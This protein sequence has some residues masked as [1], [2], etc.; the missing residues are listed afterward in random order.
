[1]P[2][3]SKPERELIILSV[4]ILTN[5][6][7][8][9]HSSF[10]CC[11]PELFGSFMI[12]T[13]SVFID[14]RRYNCTYQE[15][16]DMS[17]QRDGT[18]LHGLGNLRNVVQLL[19]PCY[20]HD[21]VEQAALIWLDAM[22]NTQ[23]RQKTLVETF[24]LRAREW[25]KVRHVLA[26]PFSKSSITVIVLLCQVF[27]A[28]G[29]AIYEQ[30]TIP[31]H[32]VEQLLL[33]TRCLESTC[34][35]IVRWSSQH[36]EESSLE[37]YILEM[38]RMLDI[39]AAPSSVICQSLVSNDRE[40]QLLPCLYRMSD[41][42][43]LRLAS[44]NL[45]STIMRH[46][47][48]IVTKSW[49]SSGELHSTFI[50]LQTRVLFAQEWPEDRDDEALVHVQ[51]DLVLR[52]V[53]CQGESR[54][55]TQEIVRFVFELLEKQRDL[56]V[57]VTHWALQLLLCFLKRDETRVLILTEYL[58]RSEVLL[59]LSQMLLHDSTGDHDEKLVMTVLR[60]ITRDSSSSL[61]TVPRL[62]VE[63]GCVPVLY[64]G[65]ASSVTRDLCQSMLHQIEC[66]VGT[67]RPGFTRLFQS[68]RANSQLQVNVATAL[69]YFTTPIFHDLLMSSRG[70]F[71]SIVNMLSS[72]N[73]RASGM[74][75][76][77]NILSLWH[78]ND[79]KH[80]DPK[81]L[82]RWKIHDVPSEH[83]VKTFSGSI[84]LIAGKAR[85]R[86]VMTKAHIGAVSGTF[87]HQFVTA[88]SR[89]KHDDDDDDD[90]DDRDI[91]EE[92][93]VLEHYR[94]ETLEIL[95]RLLDQME[96]THEEHTRSMLE[97][98]LRDARFL[99]LMELFQFGYEFQIPALHDVVG[100]IVTS[101]LSP[102]NVWSCCAQAMAYP[103]PTLL[104]SIFEF[105]L[106][107]LEEKNEG[108]DHHMLQH[109]LMSFLHHLHSSSQQ[110]KG[111]E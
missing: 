43:E 94:A 4:Y 100:A 46:E 96:H 63:Q 20:P 21:V 55:E 37:P 76:L 44:L 65:L 111:L 82:L 24:S 66:Q 61:S 103:H 70:G 3:L 50:R 2:W 52:A 26:S 31:F 102:T 14:P 98:V 84:T 88:A 35:T 36:S 23:W 28:F 5:K 72:A 60:H 58:A 10:A 75:F 30:N 73:T 109:S 64:Q 53:Q 86:V 12:I 45:L 87:Y 19:S 1:M 18:Y 47:T 39:V 79:P 41:H 81:Q 8:H 90:D 54:P 92:T 56:A 74:A 68:S 11:S 107:M 57:R 42:S 69:L 97:D 67:L 78:V 22:H 33:S 85:A 15:H 59:V 49:V 77:T 93:L 9:H 95:A 108:L 91:S 32:E 51:F 110:S 6:H 99:T 38:L 105:I 104:R 89:L 34:V 7:H 40:I 101:V 29:R 83:D 25:E 71:E 48:Q 80:D 13:Y 27:Q 17:K 106:H 62:L 16:Q